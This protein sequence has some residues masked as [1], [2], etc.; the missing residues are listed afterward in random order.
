MSFAASAAA[1]WCLAARQLGWRP[2]EFW[3]STPEEL[4]AALG[5]RSEPAAI[6]SGTL[7]RM[8]EQDRG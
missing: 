4:T 3:R 8:M 6:D 1:L 5:P 7:Q 2:E